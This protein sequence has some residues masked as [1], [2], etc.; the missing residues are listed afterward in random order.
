MAFPFVWLFVPT[1]R[2][3]IYIR[4]WV[5]YKPPAGDDNT[6]STSNTSVTCWGWTLP[7]LV[8]EPRTRMMAGD[9]GA[10][11]ASVLEQGSLVSHLVVATRI[12]I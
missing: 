6:T 5:R 11:V 10:V 4:E 9:V 8:F 7:F 12:L 3:L 1:R 2:H